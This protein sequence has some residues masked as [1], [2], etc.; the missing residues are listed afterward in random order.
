MSKK[1]LE[2]HSPNQQSSGS[3]AFLIDGE[4]KKWLIEP[5]HVIFGLT[6]M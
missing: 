1:A 4:K 6:L 5:Y 3:A 2:Q